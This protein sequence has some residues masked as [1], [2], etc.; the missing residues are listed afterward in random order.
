MTEEMIS[1]YKKLSTNEKRNELSALIV[2][3]DY[4]ID[5]IMSQKGL[6]LEMSNSKN[7]DS[8][9]QSNY[10]EDDLLLF[11]YDDIWNIKNKVLALLVNSMGGK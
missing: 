3:L 7:Y 6:S 1:L 10:T 2:K 9:I 5:Q 11:F 8:A 4:L